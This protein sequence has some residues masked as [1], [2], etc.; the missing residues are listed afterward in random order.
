MA[1]LAEAGGDRGHRVGS[2]S[3]AAPRSGVV[4]DAPQPGEREVDPVGAVAELVV[5][6]VQDLLELEQGEHPEGG[7]TG[8]R[9]AGRGRRGRGSRRGRRPGRRA[10]S[11]ASMDRPPDG[12]GWRTAYESDR[13][14]PARSRSGRLLRPSGLERS[15][16]LALEVEDHPAAGRVQRLAEVEVAVVA[17]HGPGV[18]AVGQ[19]RGRWRRPPP[20]RRPATDSPSRA[21][22]RG[23]TSAASDTM[24]SAMSVARARPPAAG[25]K[26]G[27]AAVGAEAG[28]QAGQGGAELVEQWDDRRPAV[29]PAEPLE[30]ELPPVTAVVDEVLRDGEG[31]DGAVAGGERGPSGDGRDVVVALPAEEAQHL[32]LGVLAVLDAAE[33]LHDD[34][35]ADDHRGVRLL[36]PERADGSVGPG[37]RLGG[38]LEADRAARPVTRGGDRPAPD[39]SAAPVSGSAS[40][41]G[42]RSPTSRTSWYRASP[43][44]TTEMTRSSPSAGVGHAGD[45]RLGAL[46]PEPP[47]AAQPLGGGGGRLSSRVH[48]R[49]HVGGLE[50]GGQAH[51]VAPDLPREAV[52]RRAGPPPRRSARGRGPQGSRTRPP[53]SCAASRQT[54]DRTTS[55][56]W[57]RA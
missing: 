7:A 24:R 17:Q 2:R 56:P 9:A 47:L 12:R 28:V 21:A 15:G 6:L 52:A 14:R 45:R 50:A 10:P 49:Q 54:T 5:E 37:L 42:W 33:D 46:G 4:D 13:S 55:A 25:A 26:S 36:G 23:S 20:G 48:H 39:P 34:L 44:S 31:R 27:S 19:A 16:R 29:V 41:S 22:T 51:V 18:E 57:R 8:W 32:E 35:L 30:H 38:P 53:A 43:R 11:R 3:R 40:V 1:T